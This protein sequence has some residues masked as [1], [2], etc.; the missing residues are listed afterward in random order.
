MFDSRVL[1]PAIGLI[2]L[3]LGV[4][5]AAT[6]IQEF[7][8]SVTRLRAATLR[9]GLKNILTQGQQG[10]SF[11]DSLMQHPVIAPRGK[12]PSYISAEQFSTGVIHLLGQG[13]GVPTAIASLRV[14][15]NDVPNSPIKAVATSLFREEDATL[16]G[17]ERRLQHWFD[18][19]MNG[20][21]GVYKR[22]SQYLSF[23]IGLVLAF[24]FQINAIG[25]GYGLWSNPAARSTV[26]G[27]AAK[28]SSTASKGADAIIGKL[29]DFQIVP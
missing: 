21:S 18:Q 26:A 23:A 27:A 2:F 16:E 1:D 13:G 29:A 19:S 25:I 8:A 24:V 3:F 12:T 7:L 9:V 5:L 6:A 20:L 15:V 4:S 11:Y 14:A 10:L 17:F 22:I 28:A